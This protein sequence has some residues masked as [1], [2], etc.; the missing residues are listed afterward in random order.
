MDPT[1]HEFDAQQLSNYPIVDAQHE[2]I[3]MQALDFQTLDD[4]KDK[5]DDGEEGGEALM[6][7]W[8]ENSDIVEDSVLAATTQQPWA[9]LRSSLSNPELPSTSQVQ[10]SGD[11]QVRARGPPKLT[12]VGGLVDGMTTADSGYHSGARTSCMDVEGGGDLDDD[13]ASIAT[14]GSPSLLPRQDRYLLEAEF[15]REMFNRSSASTRGQ[16]AEHGQTVMDLLYSFSVMIG[17]RASSIAERGAASFVRRG[18]K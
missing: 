15:A 18:R 9:V 5:D 3:C 12:D 16:F 2:A 6:P 1:I 4:D 13:A 7:S 11:H 14:N 10:G 17:G 8:V